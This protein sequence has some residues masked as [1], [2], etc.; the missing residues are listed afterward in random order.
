MGLYFSCNGNFSSRFRGIHSGDNFDQSTFARAVFADK[1]MNFSAADA[2]INLLQRLVLDLH[3]VHLDAVAAL[4]VDND[5][6]AVLAEQDGV[7]TADPFAID[8]QI[9]GEW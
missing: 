2:E 3:V 5:R 8:A 7:V 4:E 6:G 9:A 1:A